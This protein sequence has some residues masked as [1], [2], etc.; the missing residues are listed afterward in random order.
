MLLILW[1]WMKKGGKM[2]ELVAMIMLRI[3]VQ[4]PIDSVES[5]SVSRY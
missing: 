3:R 2:H 4:I 1:S 5:E